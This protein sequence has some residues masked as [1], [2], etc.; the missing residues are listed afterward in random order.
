[1]LFSSPT[2]LFIFLP[3]FL[4]LNF[5]F[6]R[7][8]RNTFLILAS[9]LF[10]A[11]GEPTYVLTLIFSVV[12]NYLF[13]WLIDFSQRAEKSI[14]AST[15]LGTAVA[16]NILILMTFKYTAF[17][18][19][20]INSVLAFFGITF[21][22][23]SVPHIS[24]PLG[25]SFFTFSAISYLIDV[26]QKNVTFERNPTYV[27][28]YISYFPK[29]LA[30]PL[31][32]YRS[33]KDQISKPNITIE[34]TSVGIQRFIIGL[35]KKVLI[36]DTLGI[37]ADQIFVLSGSQLTPAISWFG[38]ICYS[39]QIYFDFSGYSDMAIG[40]GKMG[41]FDFLENFNYPYIS[42]SIQE[43]WRRWHI[44][45]SS[46][47]R[48]Y[49][50]IPLGGSRRSA[51]R[52]SFNLMIVFILCG[53]WHGAGWTFVM[54]GAWHGWFLVLE[55]SRLGQLLSR[56]WSPIRHL[57]LLLIVTVGWVLFRSES[58]SSAGVYIRT[59]IGLNS[60]VLGG[61]SILVYLNTLVLITLI[62]GCILSLPLVSAIFRIKGKMLATW[63]GKRWLNPNMFELSFSSVKLLFLGTILI[64]SMI[65]LSGS[66]N[67]PFIYFRF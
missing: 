14:S 59:M 27:A 64:G 26:Y 58:L 60:E 44:S 51:I 67:N 42:Q 19:D 6:I 33:L 16:C 49:L 12:M 9:L 23:F 17:F 39:L 31:V 63:N 37:V 35:G 15:W 54:W 62:A 61:Q 32:Q 8:L 53:L 65:S 25:L 30:G 29:L 10:Y 21:I 24:L 45:L 20:T 56:I 40:I 3:L 7:Y 18:A 38:A 66:L 13:S 50:Y 11:W 5:I 4:V 57:Y 55:H 28:L 52:V 2:F 48:D 34:K 22:Q 46:W 43:F 1:M 41:G 47:L 36:A